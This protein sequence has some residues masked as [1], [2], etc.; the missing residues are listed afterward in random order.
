MTTQREEEEFATG[1]SQILDNFMLSVR[2][3]T[4]ATV[5]SYDS[6]TQ[7]AVVQPLLMRKLN[8]DPAA[9]L[10][11]EI[12]DVMVA[13]WGNGEWTATF[14]LQPGTNVI[15]GI[16]DRSIQKW[17]VDGG[18]IDPDVPRHHNMTDAIILGVINPKPKAA[19]LV[20]PGGGIEIRKIDGS[21]RLRL[22]DAVYVTDAT[23]DII[24]ID[25]SGVTINVPLTV[26]DDITAVGGDI[27]TDGDV[28]ADGDMVADAAGT[29]VTALGHEHPTAAV[30]PPSPPTP[31]T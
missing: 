17:K 21:L 15:L 14:N 4:V 25:S 26:N 13:T 8:T 5:T 28:L 7:T 23:Q 2:T 11:P 1:L 10:P 30:G 3:I 27:V 6:T 18:A 29:P 31:G 20:T 22:D 12:G 19:E 16:C 9:S 24:K